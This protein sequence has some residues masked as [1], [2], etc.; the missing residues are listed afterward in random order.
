VIV[1]LLARSVLAPIPG[2]AA[3]IIGIGI[4]GYIAAKWAKT[5]GFY[6]GALVGAGWIAL[7]ALGAVPTAAYSLDVLTDTVIVF[8]TDALVLFA[9]AFGGWRGYPEPS[10]SSDKGKGR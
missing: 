5:S 9:G 8:A 3:T 7:E 10:S 2:S 4:G 6:H 1:A